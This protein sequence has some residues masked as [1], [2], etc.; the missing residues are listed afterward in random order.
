MTKIV[1]KV[2]PFHSET[3]AVWINR[4]GDLMGW[5]EYP[6][7]S[8]ADEEIEQYPEYAGWTMGDEDAKR[9]GTTLAALRDELTEEGKDGK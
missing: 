3:L 7:G 6:G 1:R 4:N 5:Y 2:D 8:T 9:C